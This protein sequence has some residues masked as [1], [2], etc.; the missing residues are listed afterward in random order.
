MQFGLRFDKPDAGSKPRFNQDFFDTYGF[1]NNNVVSEGTIQPRIG[2]NYDM[3]DELSMQLRGGIGVFTGGAANVW[4]S[5]PFTNPGGN[6][7]SF[8]IFGYDGYIPDGL[9]QVDPGAAN[10]PAQNVDVIRP[11]FKLPT[12]LK[13]NIALDAELPWYGLQA[14]VEYEYTL[15]LIHI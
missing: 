1:A 9:A 10:P 7:N 11:G 4:L 6:V 3:S 5:N 14:T 13:S 8:Q 2:F 15:S 12:V